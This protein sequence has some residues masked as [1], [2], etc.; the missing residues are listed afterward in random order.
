MF[1]IR[2]VFPT[3]VVYSYLIISDAG[4]KSQIKIRGVLKFNIK[5]AGGGKTGRG[6]L[7]SGYIPASLEIKLMQL[8]TPPP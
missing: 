8:K 7:V 6:F 2:R 4:K 5:L 1:P 3:A